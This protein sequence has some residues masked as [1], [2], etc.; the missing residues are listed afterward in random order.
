MK[1]DP[2]LTPC[3]KVK[4]KWTR[5]LNIRS[6]TIKLL[7]ENIRGNFFDTGLDDDFLDVTPKAHTTKAKMDKWDYNKLQSSCTAK[8]T[9]NKMKR[10]ILG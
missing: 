4:S 7:E 1:L 3:T 2:Y 5:D 9:T 10:Q 8:G 6:E